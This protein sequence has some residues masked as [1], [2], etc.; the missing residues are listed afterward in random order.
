MNILEKKFNEEM[1]DIYYTTK[2]EIKYNSTRFLQLVTTDGG[3]KAAK[4]LI[5]KDGGTYG[6]ERLWK[7]NR[8]D[9]SVEALVLKPK[10]KDLFT[11]EERKICRIRLKDYNYEIE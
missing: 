8:L 1:Y 9:L 10:Y 7:E 2:K 5:S 11:D 4:K 3:I 6:F